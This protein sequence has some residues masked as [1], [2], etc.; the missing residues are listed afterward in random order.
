MRSHIFIAHYNP[1]VIL[2]GSCSVNLHM[3]AVHALLVLINWDV[4]GCM[5]FA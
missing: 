2:C 5:N 3:F 1:K 4:E